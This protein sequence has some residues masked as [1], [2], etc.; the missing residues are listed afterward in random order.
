MWASSSA[1]CATALR[2]AVVSALCNPAT[3]EAATSGWRSFTIGRQSAHEA[4]WAGTLV[5]TALLNPDHRAREG[6]SRTVSPRCHTM[7]GNVQ[8][9]AQAKPNPFVMQT[10]VFESC[11][12]ADHSEKIGGARWNNK[13]DCKSASVGYAAKESKKRRV[14]DWSSENLH[15][16]TL[17]GNL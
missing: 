17:D 12:R 8:Q 14:A 9:L 6:V 16:L 4:Q 13:A 15:P 1:A 11:V 2:E 3:M 10:G 7:W 5:R